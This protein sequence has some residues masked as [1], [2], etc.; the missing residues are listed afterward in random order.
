MKTPGMGG[1]TT[2]LRSRV[3]NDALA[4]STHCLPSLSPVS[5]GSVDVGR[6]QSSREADT[7][8]PGKSGV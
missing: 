3:R 1:R 4:N 8:T 6:E 2:D 5:G 7:H